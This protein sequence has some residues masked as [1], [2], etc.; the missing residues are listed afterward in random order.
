[1]SRVRFIF[2]S[3]IVVLSAC[4]GDSAGD[5]VVMP[6]VPLVSGTFVGPV[7]GLRYETASTDG[8]TDATG[9]FEYRD[10]EN[11][12]FYVGDILLGEV[13][14]GSEISVL[15]LAGIESP[16]V[17][18]REVR[19]VVNQIESFKLATPFEVA[20]N[21]AS[22]L[23]T[24][25][26]D[27]DAGNGIRISSDLHDLAVGRSI[28]FMLTYDKF[29]EQ[30]PL[31]KLLGEAHLYDIFV[32][33]RPLRN[34]GFAMDQLYQH[35]LGVQPQIDVV[36]E[37]Q[38]DEGNDGVIDSIEKIVYDLGGYLTEES[39]DHDNDG[40][41]DV[42]QR[43]SYEQVSGNILK[44]ESMSHIG[45]KISINYSYDARGL[46]T[47]EEFDQYA[48]DTF[49][50]V[51]GYTYNEYGQPLLKMI[52]SDL[53]GHADYQ[54]TYVYDLHGN[55][56]G[57]N[58]DHDNNGAVDSRVV[59]TFDSNGCMTSKNHYS[60]PGSVLGSHYRATCNEQGWITSEASDALGNGDDYRYYVEYA[61]N[62]QPSRLSV[63]GEFADGVID[64]HRVYT[65]NDDGYLV[66]QV[67]EDAATG[68]VTSISKYTRDALGNIVSYSFDA[69]NDGVPEQSYER[70]YDLDGA[71]RSQLT[72]SDGDGAV[73]VREVYTLAQGSQWPMV[74]R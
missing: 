12:R 44:H 64:Y 10:G 73:D 67:V 55:Q 45:P 66:K 6:R 63:D 26:D 51:I 40:V 46:R 70:S 27:A 21:I 37:T 69:N 71:A 7:E 3:L 48:D 50:E 1:M 20:A 13:A 52:D 11:V 61:E 36:V 5:P 34:A 23:Y 19:A 49:D 57:A 8:V 43:N 31:M 58:H 9:A 47:Q 25:D 74:L 62:G 35:V 54:T 65:Y 53:D 39:V 15:D 72:D 30:F 22:F 16:P 4:D 18:A 33:D 29:P 60:E 32:A 17:T 24:V 14:G 28:N 56:I 59:Y 68:D 38:T 2:F 41:V 42:M